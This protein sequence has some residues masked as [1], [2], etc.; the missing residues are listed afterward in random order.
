VWDRQSKVRL[1]IGPLRKAQFEDFLPHGTAAGSLKRFFRL[2]VG[3]TFDC[4]VL[5]ILDKRDVT[6]AGLDTRMGG[7]RLGWNGWI[8]SGDSMCDA[9]DASYLIK[10]DN[11]L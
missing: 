8:M 11:S 9:R 7:M 5:L 2:M 6:A 1:T 10:A 3:A 4:E